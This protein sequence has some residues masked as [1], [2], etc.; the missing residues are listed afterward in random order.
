MIGKKDHPEI[1]GTISYC[2]DNSMI[3]ENQQDV[4][5]AV[6]F[7]L[8]SG[9]EKVALLCQTTYSLNKFFEIEDILKE[10]FESLDF[11]IL[12]TIC[13]ATELRQKETEELSKQ[14]DA[15]VIIGGKNSSNTTKLYEIA[16]H[17]TKTYLIETV[18]D[19]DE[20]IFNYNVVG[21]TAGAST[22]K[23]SIDDVLYYL[24][25]EKL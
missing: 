18:D 6:D 19:L 10:K 7:V 8:N 23:E 4:D 12:N 15:M 17:N 13:N 1:I 2:N 21:V 22:P 14:V 24:N 3:I 16:E 9:F 5:K 25:K 11:K 20:S